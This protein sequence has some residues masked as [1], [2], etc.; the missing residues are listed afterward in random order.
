M[1]EKS[2]RENLVL[3]LDRSTEIARILENSFRNKEHI[4]R[5]QKELVEN[6]M[7]LGVQ[8]LSRE[9]ALFIFYIV[10]Q[11][12]ATVS[13]RLYKRARELF[14]KR[15]EL[16]DP[17]Y[18]ARLNVE[19]IKKLVSRK[20][21]ARFPNE[22]AFRWY[23]NSIKLTKEYRGDPR[24]LFNVSKDACE[25]LS[26][27]KEFR[28]F[29]P[30]TGA[31]L[32]R[33]ISNLGF[34]KLSHVSNVKIPVDV[35]DVRIAFYTHSVSGSNDVDTYVRN[36]S[37][38]ANLVQ[39]LWSRSAGLARVDWLILDRA[40]WLL[41]SKACVKGKHLHCPLKNFCIKGSSSLEEQ[42]LDKFVKT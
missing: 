15:A 6:Q 39:N 3:N 13:V 30:K 21:G 29:G 26:H 2:S 33:A 1:A 17:E 35:H 4:F 23:A 31:L 10:P 28:G 18:V 34:A 19:D 7:P 42:Q 9:H 41:G 11:D 27:I 16:F 32:L 36:Y 12:Y 14:E 37:K 40:L 38:Y 22:A 20:I 25:V 5:D 8:P 24:R